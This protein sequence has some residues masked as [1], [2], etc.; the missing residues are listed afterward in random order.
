MSPSL[1]VAANRA[2][3][4]APAAV[5][6]AT[7]RVA[8]ASANAALAF[9]TLR[10]SVRVD[11]PDQSRPVSNQRFDR[12]PG[13]SASFRSKERSQ[14]WNTSPARSA[15]TGAASRPSARFSSYRVPGSGT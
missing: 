14:T 2:P 1:S 12:P 6:S 15:A 9:A 11:A 4:A 13:L 3:M 10:Y 8:V 5:F 7:L